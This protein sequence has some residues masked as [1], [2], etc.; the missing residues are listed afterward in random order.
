VCDHEREGNLGK[1]SGPTTNEESA[2]EHGILAVCMVCC[3]RRVMVDRVVRIITIFSLCGLT[4]IEEVDLW[5]RRS[6]SPG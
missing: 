6:D 3:Y 5:M 4:R 2:N 1:K